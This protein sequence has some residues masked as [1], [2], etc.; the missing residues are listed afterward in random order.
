M[1][2]KLTPEQ[3]E[4]LEVL[5]ARWDHVSDPWPLPT[6]DCVCVKVQSD[7]TGVGMIIGIEVDGNRHS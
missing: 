1:Q 5:K 3:E 2:V 7:E 4:S 6:E